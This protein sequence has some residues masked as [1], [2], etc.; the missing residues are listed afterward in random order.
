MLV[1]NHKHH[2]VFIYNN[3]TDDDLLRY[4]EPTLVEMVVSLFTII[5]RHIVHIS[6]QISE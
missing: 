4:V 6:P 2:Q 1:N 5:H 3:T